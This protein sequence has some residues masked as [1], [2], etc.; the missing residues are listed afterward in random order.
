[1][2]SII[3]GLGNIGAKYENSRHNLGFELL[4]ILTRKWKIEPKE[5]N[6]DYFFAL[7]S[8]SGEKIYLVWP[9]TYMNNSGLAVSQILA[10]LSD[11]GLTHK[12]L[13]IIYDDFNLPLGKIRIRPEGSDGGHNGM[14]S[15]IYHLGTQ[16]ITRLRMGV[17]PI[18]A[19]KN[20]IDFVLSPFGKEELEIKNKMLEKSVEAVLYL[21]NNNAEKAMSLFN[22]SH[23]NGTENDNP[24]P[25]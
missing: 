12:N 19:N 18:P 13:L 9:T 11:K 20:V 22:Q 23:E 17:G 10:E 1:M 7:K 4:D 6:G 8:L 15:I 16:E 3:I 21:L 14:T 5:G 24:A 2:L 25:E